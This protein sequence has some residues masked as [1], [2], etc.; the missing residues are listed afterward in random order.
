MRKLSENKLTFIC[1]ETPHCFLQTRWRRNYKSPENEEFMLLMT[2]QK[3]AL[4]TKHI[5]LT[6]KAKLELMRYYSEVLTKVSTQ[7]FKTFVHDDDDDEPLEEDKID[8]LIKESLDTL[9]MGDKEVEVNPLEE[10]DDLVP[11]PRVSEKHFDSFSKTFDTTI[12]NPLFDF[13]SEFTLNSDN[14][15]FDIQNEDSDES[16]TKTIVDE[17]H[18]H[19]SQSTAHVPPPYILP[20]PRVG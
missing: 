9:S 11:I 2:R 10:I 20:E 12:T 18:I 17:V 16:D 6:K 4:L 3:D 14:Q 5:L 1:V 15:I 13:D 19:S 8:P 7:F